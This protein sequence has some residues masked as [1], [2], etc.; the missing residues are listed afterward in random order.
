MMSRVK[1]NEEKGIV[2][3]KIKQAIQSRNITIEYSWK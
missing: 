1:E 2:L 3:S